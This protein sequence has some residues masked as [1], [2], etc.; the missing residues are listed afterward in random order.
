MDVVEGVDRLTP[1]LGR[2]FV[3]IGVFDGIHVGHQYLLRELLAAA[4]AR[5]ARP[6]V[7][8]F[9]H[10]PD[11]ILVGNAPPLLCDPAERLALL[12]AAGVE[13]IVIQH[14]DVALRQTPYDRF[15]RAIADR[16]Q[17]AGFL[18]TPDSAFGFE[19]RGTPETVATLGRELGYDV[20]TVPPFILD[21]R[22]VSSSEIRS[23]IA[24]GDLV[25]AARLLGR[26]YAV[27]GMTSRASRDPV[28]TFEMPAALPPPGLYLTRIHDV[29]EDV[30]HGTHH[31]HVQS[32]GIRLDGIWIGGPR[33]RLIFEA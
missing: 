2:L 19:R 6:T 7:I 24:T 16:V 5:G 3:A 28:L 23:A 25:A 22:P 17:L 32:T 29:D 1:S 27:V 13:V 26:P 4:A 33:L 8:T 31:A 21:G 9:D 12:E 14:F 20:V 15:I 10:H 18:M 30:D 11:E